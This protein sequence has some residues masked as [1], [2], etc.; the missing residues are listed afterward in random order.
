MVDS[1]AE[2]KQDYPQQ[3]LC[4][5]MGMD[6][7]AGF[8]QWHRWQSIL[9]LCHLVIATRPGVPIPDFA[10]NQPLIDAALTEDASAL[11]R[12]QQ[13]QILLQS[14]TLLDISATRIRQCLLSGQS[15]RYLVPE[16]VR[17]RLENRY[18]I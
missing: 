3:S 15:I 16:P 1:L 5:I 17:E 7:F 11:S 2:L 8:T 6:A 18:A 9:G 12:S 13:G 4:L 10:S 14:V